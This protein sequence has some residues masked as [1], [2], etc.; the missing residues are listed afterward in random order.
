MKVLWLLVLSFTAS[1]QGNEEEMRD[2]ITTAAVESG[3]TSQ[4]IIVY[5]HN[6]NFQAGGAHS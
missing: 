3:N 4:G 1:A 5:V 2:S 6:Y